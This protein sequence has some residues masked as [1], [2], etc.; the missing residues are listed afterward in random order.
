MTMV[1]FHGVCPLQNGAYDTQSSFVSGP[2]AA[3]TGV[4]GVAS[5]HQIPVMIA[6]DR[7]AS[8]AKIATGVLICARTHV[9]QGKS[10]PTPRL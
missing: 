1:D 10:S 8:G 7:T 2:I 6:N 4:T 9:P 5:H 3:W